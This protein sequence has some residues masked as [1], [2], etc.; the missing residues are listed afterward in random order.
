MMATWNDTSG[1][2]FFME[3]Y[4]YSDDKVD[5]VDSTISYY[6]FLNKYGE[7]YIMR[8]DETNGTGRYYKGDSGY[9]SAWSARESASYDYFDEIFK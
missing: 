1:F 8:K 4:F 2:M 6:G 9:S 5:S 3:G 7:W